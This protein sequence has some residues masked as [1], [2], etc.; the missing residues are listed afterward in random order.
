MTPEHLDDV[1]ALLDSC[2]GESAWSMESLRSQM[3]KAD[4][5]CTVAMID[6][7]IVGF[8]AFEQ[9][10]D[11]GSIVEVAVR[12]DHRRKGIARAL[13][14]SALSDDSLKEIFLEVR[15]SNISAIRLYESFGFERIGIRKDYYDKPKEDAVMMKKQLCSR[16][17]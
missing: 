16:G 5:R 7:Q 1:K 4:S 14:E 9:I 10:A 17:S 15:E 12:L 11:E 3:E 2:F 8:L 6:N 13:I